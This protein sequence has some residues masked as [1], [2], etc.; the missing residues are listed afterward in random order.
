MNLRQIPALALV[1]TAMTA[2]AQEVNE[3]DDLQSD[4]RYVDEE[5]QWLPHSITV[6]ERSELD[7]TN[8]SDIEDLESA[9]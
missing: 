7:A 2:S 4:L 5:T 1:V 8:R 9:Q 6:L 3:L